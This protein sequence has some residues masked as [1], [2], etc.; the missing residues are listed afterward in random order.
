[1]LRQ[2]DVVRTLVVLECWRQ[3]KDFGS[4][5]VPLMI[6][7]CLANR[8]RLGWSNWFETLKNIPKYSALLKQPNRDI[9]PD[10][11]EPNFIRLLQSVEGV[12]EG[13]MIDPACG[14]VF[15]ADLRH[16]DN[17]WFLAKVLND[18][19]RSPCANLNSFTIFK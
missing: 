10:L 4:S 18:P 2:D 13:S 5:Q 7:G 17:P 8:V 15:W 9:F 12:M 3:G 16:I 11:W 6:M 14:G 1:M 19:L